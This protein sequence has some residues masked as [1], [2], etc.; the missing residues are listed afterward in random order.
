MF[1]STKSFYELLGS[2]E[3]LLKKKVLASCEG[4]NV[5][6]EMRMD[7]SLNVLNTVHSLFGGFLIKL[8][9]KSRSKLM[10]KIWERI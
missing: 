6:C 7:V 3:K 9:V 5:K 10:N 2:H 8:I 4:L 1:P